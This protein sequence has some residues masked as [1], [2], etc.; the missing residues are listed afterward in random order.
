MSRSQQL[1]L[2]H[3]HFLQTPFQLIVRCHPTIRRYTDSVTGSD[4]QQTT[5]NR[6]KKTV[7]RYT[8]FDIR[9][10]VVRILRGLYP[11]PEHGRFVTQKTCFP[12][13]YRDSCSVQNTGKRNAMLLKIS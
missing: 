9:Q 10:S 4:V 5:K 11:G 3:G 6:Q 8:V 7:N 13:K 1:K 2:G 12:L